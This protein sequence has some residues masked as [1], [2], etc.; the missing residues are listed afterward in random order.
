VNLEIDVIHKFVLYN[1][2]AMRPWIALYEEKRRKRDSDRKSF[3]RLNGRS[4]FKRKYA[5]N[6]S[7]QLGG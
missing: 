6:M 4:I 5:K 2:M 7:Q 3:R 1:M